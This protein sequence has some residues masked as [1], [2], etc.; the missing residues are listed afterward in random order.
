ML[1]TARVGKHGQSVAALSICGGGS[2]FPRGDDDIGRGKKAA[3]VGAGA[4]CF[5]VC[6]RFLL[7]MDDDDDD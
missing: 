5:F 7:W 4:R 6:L 2:T 1:C 3:W